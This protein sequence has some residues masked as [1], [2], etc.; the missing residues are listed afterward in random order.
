M[1]RLKE[2]AEKANELLE[3]FSRE[4][5]G[6]RYKKAVDLPLAH[7]RK[8]EICRALAS[9]PALLLLDEPAAGMETEET[10]H[11]M[12]DIRR[13]LEWKKDMGIIIIEHDM[14]VIKNIADRVLVINYGRKIAEGAFSQVCEVPEVIEAYLGESGC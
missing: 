10:G 7:R 8:L 14:T 12:E 5:L 11:L 3:F 13:I 4:L 6:D 2:S 9:D 1:Q